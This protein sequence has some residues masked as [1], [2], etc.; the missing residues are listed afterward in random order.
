MKESI[1][2]YKNGVY[3]LKYIDVSESKIPYR[4]R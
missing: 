3:W 2:Y 1:E 4:D